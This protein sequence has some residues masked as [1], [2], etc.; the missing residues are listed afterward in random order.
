MHMG[1]GPGELEVSINNHIRSRDARNKELFEKVFPEVRSKSVQL[2]D[3]AEKFS[4]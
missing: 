3:Q 2:R 1:W 4:R